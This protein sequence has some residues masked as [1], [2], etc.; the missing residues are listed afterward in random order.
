MVS[1]R[2]VVGATSIILAE[3][4]DGAEFTAVTEVDVTAVPLSVPSLGVAVTEMVSPLL[5]LELVS[6][7]P[8]TPDTVVPF[9]LQL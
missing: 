2:P 6:V 3:E 9:T 1:E 7:L 8:V 5:K 4:R